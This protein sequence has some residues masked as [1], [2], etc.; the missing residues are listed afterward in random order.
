MTLPELLRGIAPFVRPYRRLA[1]LA[2]CLTLLGACVSQI[3][4][5]V[6]RYVVDETQSLLAARDAAPGGPLRL[7]T[8][9]AVVL[10]GKEALL[11]LIQFGQK[12]YGEKLRVHIARDLS[13]SVIER[14]LTYKLAFYT[15][16]G[17]QPGRLQARIDRGVESLARLTQILFVD[18]LP[19]FATSIVA[20]AMMFSA[21]FQIGL[22]GVCVI[23]LYYYVSRAQ[24]LRLT[25]ARRRIK[26]LREN[27]SQGILSILEAM[28][29]IK[30]F[31]REA[32]EEE[33]QMNLQ[34]DLSSA[35]LSIRRTNFLFD[36]LKGLIE[37]L[38]LIAVVL[39]S[40]WLVLQGELS[41]GGIMFHILLFNNAS[42][43]IRRL[44]LLY[45]QMNDALTYAEGFFEILRADSQV[46]DSG[47]YAPARLEGR[48]ELRGVSFSYPGSEA[49]SLRELS[50]SIEPGR[51]TALVGLSGAGKST[52]INL[53]DKFYIPDA[54]EILLDGVPLSAY[55]TA[56]VRNN[57]GLV[58]QKNHIFSGTAEE[59]IRYGNP[60]AAQPELEEAARRACIHE[61]LLALPGGY[62]TQARDL[63]GG[64]QQKLALARVFLKNPPILFLDEPTA[65]LDAVAAE[66]IKNCLD[67]VKKDRTV[68]IISHNLAQ[69]IDADRIHVLKDG[70]V[71]ESGTHEDI[72]RLNGSYREIFDAL[73][74]SL[75][76]DKIARSFEE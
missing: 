55:D 22:L 46:E 73:A 45:D 7:L 23:P 58:L 19:L 1:V 48:F 66:E 50:L 63:S 74:R 53:L 5:W 69:I 56:F 72:Y 17:N 44:H 54:G 10:L 30:S 2:V 24:A 65:S 51:V 59:N 61:D 25:P 40:A 67:A 29:V 26:R 12:Y 9:V 4:A 13:Q 64:Q 27:K 28:P 32:V 43:P 42:A 18:I 70:R 49:P 20:A 57:I 34:R 47:G 16:C 36:G 3:N 76:M 14:I 21:N 8:F 71:V 37:Q 38:G 52:L 35:Q 6:L 68:V 31:L 11:L 33:R 62:A 15:S 75:N 41:L 39:L 60:S